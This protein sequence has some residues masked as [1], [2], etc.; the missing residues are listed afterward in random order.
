MEMHKIEFA[1][2][3]REKALQ[4]VKVRKS[5]LF[6][7][8]CKVAKLRQKLGGGVITGNSDMA[9]NFYSTFGWRFANSMVP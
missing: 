3:H 4:F 8:V 7:K 9:I 1:S 6:V 2:L 5:I